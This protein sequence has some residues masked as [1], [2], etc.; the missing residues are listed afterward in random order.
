MLADRIRGE[1]QE[2]LAARAAMS[3]HLGT[4]FQVDADECDGLDPFDQHQ[5]A[6]FENREVDAHAEPLGQFLHQPPAQVRGCA[7]TKRDQG[8]VLEL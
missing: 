4:G 3:R 2:Q 7:I 5:L 6:G 1:S 8:H